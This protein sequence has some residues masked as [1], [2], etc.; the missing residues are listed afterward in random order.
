MARQLSRRFW[1]LV[2]LCGIAA[3]G[4][5]E[6]KSAGPQPEQDRLPES[7]SVVATGT[8]AAFEKNWEVALV[9]E[10]RVDRSFVLEGLDAASAR[11]VTGAG[12]VCP[13]HQLSVGRAKPVRVPAKGRKRA[14]LLFGPCE[15]RPTAVIVKG[16][17]IPIAG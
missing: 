1:G 5:E 2:S 7:L 9:L 13:I 14:S 12:K 10:T 3:I 15:E 11:A 8:K 16:R 17:Q 6:S 4:C